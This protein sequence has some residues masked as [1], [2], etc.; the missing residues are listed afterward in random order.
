MT[1]SN[2]KFSP[3]FVASIT[4]AAIETRTN[5]KGVAYAYLAGATVVRPNGKSD[6]RTVMAF[7]K[8]REAVAEMLREGETVSL[9]VQF[10]GATVKIVGLPREAAPAA[11]AA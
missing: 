3:I 10:D 4:P 11:V 1:T 9:A 8:S 6:T 2:F 7:G 5:V